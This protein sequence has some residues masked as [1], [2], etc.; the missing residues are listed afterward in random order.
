MK[1]ST[2]VFCSPTWTKHPAITWFARVETVW[3]DKNIVSD[4]E[5][6]EFVWER[7]F[8][9]KFGVLVSTQVPLGY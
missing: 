6:G 5:V 3:I 4:R 7:C 9:P 1:E 8:A 2:A